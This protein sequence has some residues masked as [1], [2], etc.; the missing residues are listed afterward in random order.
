[1]NNYELYHHGILGMKW[2]IRRY[3]PYGQGYSPKSEGREIGEA[4]LSKL[5]GKKKLLKE[6]ESSNNEQI[7]V[8]K[9]KLSTVRSK[10][11]DRKAA[12][13]QRKINK[14]GKKA[15][16]AQKRLVKGKHISGRQA[17]VLIKKAKLEGKLANVD[18]RNSKLR[19]KISKLEVKNSRINKKIKRV[20]RK[21]LNQ[22]SKMEMQ[23]GKE[24][25]LEIIKRIGNS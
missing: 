10:K 19:Y 21:S 18:K 12:K 2:G 6:R 1:M 8:Y 24:R 20:E 25:T 9:S 16:K 23:I 11:A 4:R 14:I 3:Q 13:I 22:I 17:K 7:E 15:S 5:A